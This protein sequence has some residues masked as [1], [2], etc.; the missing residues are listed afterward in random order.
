MAYNDLSQNQTISFNNLQSGVNQGVFT[1]K[2]AIPVS[3]KQITKTE[4]NTYVN[5]NT[6][7]PSYAAKA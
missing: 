7:L 3:T 6:S 1:A 2:A 5:I 4:A